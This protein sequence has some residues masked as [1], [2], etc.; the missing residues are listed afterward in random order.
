MAFPRKRVIIDTDGG[1]DDAMAILIALQQ[2]DVIAITTVFGNVELEQATENV[3]T[4]LDLFDFG[5]V[6]VFKGAAV[7]LI[8][9][10]TPAKWTGHYTD[11]QKHCRSLLGW[12]SDFNLCDVNI[13]HGKNGLGDQTFHIPEKKKISK[14]HPQTAAQA[15]VELARQQPQV[16]S[17]IFPVVFIKHEL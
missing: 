16:S 9:L 13:G 14:V 12:F 11:P 3:Q 5:H 10:E 6:P 1:V 4:I 7:P 8:R 15:L 2:T 17:I